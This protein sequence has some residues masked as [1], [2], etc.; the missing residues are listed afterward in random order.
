M[1]I[2]EYPMNI[3]TCI[4]IARQRVGKHIPAIYMHA[5]IE[6]LSLLGER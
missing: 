4:S 1:V 2:V 5:T 6:K 3:V